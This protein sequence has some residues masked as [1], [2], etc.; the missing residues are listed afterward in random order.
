MPLSLHVSLCSILMIEG[1]YTN[2]DLTHL[3]DVY[4]VKCDFIICVF[5]LSLS[6]CCTAVASD[7]KTNSWYV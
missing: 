4:C 3:C 7:T 1:G 2:M 6:F 5:V